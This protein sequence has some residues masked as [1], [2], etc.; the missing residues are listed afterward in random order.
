M[1]CIVNLLYNEV[2][3]CGI[4]IINMNIIEIINIQNANKMNIN[5]MLFLVYNVSLILGQALF[6]ISF[7]AG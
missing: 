4:D 7:I 3:I 1:L 6:W 5:G 2:F